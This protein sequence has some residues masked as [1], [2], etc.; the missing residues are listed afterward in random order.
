MAER[1]TVVVPANLTLANQLAGGE[2]EGLRLRNVGE[3]GNGSPSGGNRAGSTCRDGIHDAGDRAT[4]SLG[5]QFCGVSRG[6]SR[7]R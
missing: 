6:R 3:R 5:S 4:L 7:R 1:R 2:A